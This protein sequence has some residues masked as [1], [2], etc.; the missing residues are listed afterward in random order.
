MNST[1]GGLSMLSMA[2]SNAHSDA[3]STLLEKGA[4]LNGQ[5]KRQDFYFMQLCLY[6]CS[7][8]EQHIQGN[9]PLLQDWPHSTT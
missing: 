1:S 2:V 6:V 9:I 5:A 3:V 8:Q 4:S 7:T